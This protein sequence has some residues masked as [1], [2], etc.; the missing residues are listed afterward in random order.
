MKRNE[1]STEVMRWTLHVSLLLFVFILLLLTVLFRESNPDWRSLTAQLAVAGL[2]YA[3]AVWAASQFARSETS[4]SLIH[5][6]ASLSLSGFL[7]GAVAQL[8]H[9]FVEGWMDL[10][11]LKWE[12]MLTGTDVCQST[13]Q[14]VSPWLTEWMMFAYVIYVPL[15]PLVAVLC[16]RSSG[17]RAVADYLLNL[18]VANM[19]CFSGFILFPIAGPM[20]QYPEMFT[21]PLDGWLFTWFGEW[22]RS[23]VHYPG[24]SL[25]SPHC[26]A[27][28]VMLVMA[29]RYQRKL[30]FALVPI[31]LTVYVAT[32]YGRY[33]YVSDSVA[34]IIAAIVVL[35]LSPRLVRAVEHLAMR[36]K[37]I[38]PVS[39]E[40]LSE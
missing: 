26:A 19:V 27:S 2:L 38:V 6:V 32:V 21:V 30:F 11:V 40:S 4:S 18:S 16:M 23:N 1:T 24:G 31:V 25:P 7:F 37:H 9:T 10:A 20:V 14:Y 8:Q 17:P 3:T 36:T 5:I 12:F 29:Y 13:Q 15:L 22:M 35:K 39:V 34:G 28:T 33:H